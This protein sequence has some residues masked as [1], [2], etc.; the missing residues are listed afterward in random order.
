MAGNDRQ[1][2][3]QIAQH[4]NEPV[5]PIEQTIADALKKRGE[6]RGDLTTDQL[7]VMMRKVLF[8]LV[9]EHKVAGIDVPIVHNVS[10]M[11][12][13]IADRAVNVFAEIQ[14][15]SP[16]DA[17]IQFRYTLENSPADNPYKRLRLKNNDLDIK[18]ITRTFDVPAKAALKIVGVKHVA[19]REL[20]NPNAL[21]QRTL[22]P[23]LEPHG[24]RGSL[25]RVELELTD[26]GTMRVY[27]V[28]K[29]AT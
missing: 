13:A 1:L 4:M 23:Q 11:D 6:F 9:A 27:M 15:R 22:P 7:S 12:V 24:F 3:S 14:V 20:S 10:T 28:G 16:I 17:F 26:E 21:I 5:A 18:E 19:I 2:R 29:H 25:S 8:T